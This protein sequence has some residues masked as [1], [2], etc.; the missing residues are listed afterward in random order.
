MLVDGSTS[1]T[2]AVEIH[3]VATSGGAD[4]FKEI[5]TTG[6]STYDVSIAIASQP[7]AM[8]SQKNKIEVSNTD[9][10]RLRVNNTSGSAIDVHVTGV[11]VSD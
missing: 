5:D 1:S 6:D 4:V 10:M 7:E 9:D 11:E 8:H 2:G 3:T